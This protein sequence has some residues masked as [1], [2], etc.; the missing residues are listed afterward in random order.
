MD[1]PET[2]ARI[3]PAEKEEGV[4]PPPDGAPLALVA[5]RDVGIAVALLS[6]FGGADAWRIATG[7]AAC[8]SPRARSDATSP[9]ARASFDLA[10]SRSLLTSSASAPPFKPFKLASC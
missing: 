3:D 1:A 6:L 7:A 8:C 2:E 5:A 10:S 4:A 9:S